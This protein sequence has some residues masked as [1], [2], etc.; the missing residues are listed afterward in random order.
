[1]IKLTNVATLFLSIP[2][3]FVGFTP[4]VIMGGITIGFSSAILVGEF[5]ETGEK[6]VRR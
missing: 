4:I 2:F 3:L 5:L 1:M 6:N